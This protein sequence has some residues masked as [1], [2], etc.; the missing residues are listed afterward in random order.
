VDKSKHM[1]DLARLILEA[2]SSS[3]TGALL[4]SGLSFRLQLP[5]TVTLKY[6]LVLSSNSL[7]ELPSAQERLSTID[8][9]W[10]RVEEG[11]YLVITDTGTNAGFHVIAEARDYLNQ[12]SRLATEQ[13]EESAGHCVSPCPHDSPCPRHSLDSIPCN[14][15]VRFRNFSFSDL[16][17]DQVH[18][19]YVSYL[20]YKK[21][22]RT[23]QS[24]PRILETPVRTK[25]SIYCRLC[26]N[27]GHL[28]E[29]LARKKDDDDLFQLGKKLRWGDMMPVK[30]TKVEN[31]K[32][33]GTPWMKHKQ[34]IE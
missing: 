20:V 32:K 31:R 30:L 7:L 15:P 6:D 13:E 22:V 24:L 33:I 4:P 34:I 2:G 21:A 1:N 3:R 11:G 28:Q 23:E 25:T 29:V 16:P 17:S 5:S 26:T 10:Q 12:I 8:S 9:L 14:F 27:T 19:E 18:T